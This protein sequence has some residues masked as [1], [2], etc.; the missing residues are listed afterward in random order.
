MFLPVFVTLALGLA[1]GAAVVVQN[2]EQ[3][4][5]IAVADQAAET[6]LS[7]VG[8]FG[9][10]VVTAINESDEADPAAL[11]KVLDQ[12]T[13]R[14]PV[15]KRVQL[16]GAERSAL[17]AEAQRTEKVFLRPYQRLRRELRRADVAVR[18]IS[19]CRDALR[20]RVTEYVGY[21]AL[22]SSDP[23]RA[24]LIPAFDRERDELAATR[25]PQGQ[26]KLAAQ[27]LDA[28]Q[29]VIDSSSRLADDIESH[30]SS[31]FSYGDRFEAARVAV[32]DYAT[33]VKG[34]LIEA[35]NAIG[36]PQ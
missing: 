19:A 34:D 23:I 21:G 29:Y 16:E 24:K 1:L 10:A 25:V 18:F 5:R 14:P 33:V 30:R 28:L 9:S 17:Y 36:Q 26:E 6:F 12:A 3:A 20:L 7:Q 15:L 2:H 35:L 32:D 22:Y 4:D 31:S 8:S 13:A 27:V 11:V